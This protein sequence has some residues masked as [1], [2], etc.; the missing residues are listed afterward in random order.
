M[1]RIALTCALGLLAAGL[2]LQLVPSGAG[3]HYTETVN[4]TVQAVGDIA[5]GSSTASAQGADTAAVA[6]GPL[7]F[8]VRARLSHVLDVSQD[9][10]GVTPGAVSEVCLK[11]WDGSSQVQSQC[12]PGVVFV[13]PLASVGTVFATLGGTEVAL[14]LTGQGSPTIAP[15]RTLEIDP[16][17]GSIGG[18]VRLVNRRQ[19]SASGVI[20]GAFGGGAATGGGTMSSDVGV[21][22]ASDLGS[23]SGGGSLPSGADKSTFSLCFG[24][25]CEDTHLTWRDHAFN[26]RIDATA[27]S[28]LVAG[29]KAT[30]SGVA[31][32]DGISGCSFEL[33]VSDNNTSSTKLDTIY[34]NVTGPAGCE[35]TTDPGG[36]ERAI[37]GGN[38]TVQA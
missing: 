35:Y 14:V 4:Q 2:A 3:Q 11:V 1:R 7:S 38:L 22:A 17:T 10:P 8:E 27:G 12:G 15:E 26:R 23:A 25:V 13:D 34:L 37:S 9:P 20:N 36:A 6:A 30:I 29:R 33:K 19:A 5:R 18:G 32:V 16:L 31:R 21:N 24:S 28:I